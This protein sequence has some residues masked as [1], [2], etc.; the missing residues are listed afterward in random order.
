MSYIVTKSDTAKAFRETCHKINNGQ[1]IDRLYVY[2]YPQS[3]RVTYTSYKDSEVAEKEYF[4]CDLTSILQG[5]YKE[6]KYDLTRAT[7]EAHKQVK[8]A[9]EGQR[10]C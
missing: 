10:L 1:P 6:R 7:A 3:E 4:I 5:Y 9:V 2:A 8:E